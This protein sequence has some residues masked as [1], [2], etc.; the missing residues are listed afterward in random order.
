MRYAHIVRSVYWSEDQG[1]YEQC[2]VS[3]RL[4][5]PADQCLLVDVHNKD[6]DEV[7]AEQLAAFDE[8]WGRVSRAGRTDRPPQGIELFSALT[9][10][11][12]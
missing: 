4:L 3:M 9:F 1:G 11:D 10:Y 2:F 7:T 5:S 8:L 12:F 6:E